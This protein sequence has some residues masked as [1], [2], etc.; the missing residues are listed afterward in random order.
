MVRGAGVSSAAMRGLYLS[1]IGCAAA[2]AVACGGSEPPAQSPEPPAPAPEPPAASA[3]AASATP[4]EAATD[5]NGDDSSS[6]DDGDKP[7]KTDET[8]EPKF[9]EGMTVDQAIAAVPQGLPRENVDQD[10]LSK[11]LTDFKVYKPCKPRPSDHF[12]LKVAVWDGKAV[13]V[14]VITKNKKLATCIDKQIRDLTWKDPVKSL[15]TI[16]YA[17]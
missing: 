9:T 13:G 10:E 6:S 7:K 14:D 16:E 11:P 2:L 3:P 1:L 15:N 5:D 4:S 8:V 17:F 12:K